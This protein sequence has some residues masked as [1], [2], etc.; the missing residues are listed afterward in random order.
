MMLTAARTAPKAVG[1]DSIVT[2]IITGD[3][4]EGL[5]DAMVEIGKER[6]GSRERHM[7]R[8]AAN[9]RDSELVVLIGVKGTP[10]PR[11]FD[12]GACGF[13]SCAE[14]LSSRRRRKDFVGPSCVFK[15]LDLGIALGSAAKMA[16]MLNVDSRMM[17]SVG[18]AASRLKVIEGDV[19]IGIPISISGKSIFFDRAKQP[20]SP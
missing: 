16:S 13:G 19:I 9:V 3:E 14:F 7:R 12:C 11:T 20:K 1:V 8:D 2:A 10:P 17:Y 5:A 18:V 15:L 6:G 4:K